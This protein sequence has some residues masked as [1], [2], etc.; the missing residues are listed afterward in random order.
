[1]TQGASRLAQAVIET[2]DGMRRVGIVCDDTHAKITLQHLGKPT[3]VAEPISGA[4]IRKVRERA[5]LSQAVFARYLNLTPATSRS[6]SAEPSSQPAPRWPCS[7]LFGARGWRVF[8]EARVQRTK[9]N[10]ADQSGTSWPNTR[11]PTH[12]AERFAEVGKMVHGGFSSPS[13]ANAPW[14][15]AFARTHR[16]G[17]AAKRVAPLAC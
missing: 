11:A 14:H 1:M 15:C 12:T 10:P 8:F 3:S 5:H 4:D 2:A 16:N 6:W 9:P 17:A 7:M 13:G